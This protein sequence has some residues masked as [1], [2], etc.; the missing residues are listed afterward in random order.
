MSDTPR[1]QTAREVLSD[2]SLSRSGQGLSVDPQQRDLT[3]S[4]PGGENQLTHTKITRNLL[5]NTPLAE[6]G[7][8]V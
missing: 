8:E 7:V 5:V 3:G 6:R 4:Q 2:S 1:L